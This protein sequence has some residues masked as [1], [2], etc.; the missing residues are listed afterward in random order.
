[1]SNIGFCE[2]LREEFDAFEMLKSAGIGVGSTT[3]W[4]VAARLNPKP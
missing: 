4:E 2:Q 1:M 3:S